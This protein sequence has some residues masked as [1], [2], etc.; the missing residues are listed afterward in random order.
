MII[1]DNQLMLVCK[2]KIPINTIRQ[3]ETKEKIRKSIS[4]EPENYSRK[5]CCKNIIKGINT[6]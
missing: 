2:I 1:K 6:S 3:V 5:V 4:G